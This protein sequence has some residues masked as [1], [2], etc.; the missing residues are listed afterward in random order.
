MEYLRHFAMAS[1][2]VPEREAMETRQAYKRRS[3]AT[4]HEMNTVPLAH[5]RCAFTNWH[6]TRNG[7]LCGKIFTVHQ[8]MGQLKRCGIRSYM[9]LYPPMFGFRRYA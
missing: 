4:L 3:Y 6:L 7:T 2:Y 9:T 5:V 8:F 1:A